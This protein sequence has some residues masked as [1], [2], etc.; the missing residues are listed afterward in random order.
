MRKVFQI[1]GL[2]TIANL[3]WAQQAE[4]RYIWFPSPVVGE[5]LE[6]GFNGT[7]IRFFNKGQVTSILNGQQVRDGVFT[8]F[9][10]ADNKRYPILES[11][12]KKLLVLMGFD[13]W[14]INYFGRRRD[15][16]A[17]EQKIKGDSP[18]ATHGFTI[19]GGLAARPVSAPATSADLLR[20]LFETP[21]ASWLSPTNPVGTR[22]EFTATYGTRTLYI[23]NGFVDLKNLAN[24][25][26][27]ARVRQIEIIIGQNS[28]RVELKDQPNFQVI[29]L[30]SPVPAGATVSVVIRSV[31]AGRQSQAALNMIIPM[32]L[33]REE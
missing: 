19:E 3:V 31:Y 13:Q 26:T 24:W 16:G 12:D 33:G 7:T 23:A 8:V 29:N 11:D 32:Y 21:A 4:Q 17:W 2:V 25:S 1:I 22:I 10:T 18:L 15:G 20:N 6:F 14:P 27:Y 9:R 30:N 28:Q 5:D